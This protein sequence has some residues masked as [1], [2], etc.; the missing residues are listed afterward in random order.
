MQVNPSTEP[1]NSKFIAFLEEYGQLLQQQG[2]QMRSRAFTL[3]AET[4][5]KLD[6]N[7]TSVEQLGKLKG[8]GK[9]ILSLLSEF[10]EKG[11]TTSL[12]LA[13][14]N[15]LNIFVKVYGIG[16]KKAQELLNKGYTSIEQ[17]KSAVSN[18]EAILNAKQMIGLKYYEDI[19]ERIP[20]TE[21][22]EYEN[23]FKSVSSSLQELQFE[24][25]GSYRRQA[26]T[27]GDIDVIVTAPTV[28][29]FNKFLDRLK[30][31]N[32]ITEFLSRGNVKSLV[33]EPP[34]PCVKNGTL[35]FVLSKNFSLC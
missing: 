24:I 22:I 17:L 11:T 15:P 20:R 30:E 21:I 14:N 25:V 1:Y 32:I 16:A 3:A 2:D 18:N 7:I 4:I 34:E 23:K 27:S 6:T 29:P 8:F 13:R 26:Q 10:A 35:L 28:E 12:E 33:V 9:T 5:M 19:L 31:Q